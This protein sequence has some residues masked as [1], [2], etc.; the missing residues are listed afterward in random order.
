MLNLS[1]RYGKGFE[2]AVYIVTAYMNI[3]AL[4][5]TSKR[6]KLKRQFYKFQPSAKENPINYRGLLLQT[7]IS[8]CF[9]RY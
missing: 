3:I 2:V 1:R 8:F 4:F 7:S 9:S 5:N 6:E